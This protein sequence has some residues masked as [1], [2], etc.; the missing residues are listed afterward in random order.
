MRCSSFTYLY[1]TDWFSERVCLFKTKTVNSGGRVPVL[2]KPCMCVMY[3]CKCDL[4][5]FDLRG[6]SASLSE[7]MS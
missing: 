4:K 2:K 3:L 7:N 5:Q 1:Y 6:G